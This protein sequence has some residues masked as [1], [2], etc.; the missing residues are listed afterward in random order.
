M[1]IPTLH[2]DPVPVD[3]TRH[4]ALRLRTPVSDWSHL[5]EVNAVFLTAVE[6]VNAC[7]DYPILFVR[8]G[9]DEQGQPDY[10]PIAALGLTSGENL[11]VEGGRWRGHYLPSVMAAYPFCV[12]RGPENR[13]AVCIDAASTH[14]AYDGE[15]ERLFD[16]AGQPTEFARRLQADLERLEAHVE[17][18]RAVVRRVAALGLLV[19]R[20]FDATLPDGRTLTVDGF[21]AVDEEKVRA[22]PDAT[23]LELN[24]DGI[25]RFIHAHWSSLGQMRRLLDWRVAR[26]AQAQG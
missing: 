22:L 8:V 3:T 18:T 21:L 26:E 2:R 23:L 20:R 25:L 12:A 24:R 19:D 16:D 6:C 15:G 7:C 4:A 14:L 10:A 13:Y 11:Y 9:V 5:A 17:S 1:I